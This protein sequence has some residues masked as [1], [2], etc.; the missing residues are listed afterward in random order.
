MTEGVGD[1]PLRAFS[2]SCGMGGRGLRV[3]GVCLCTFAGDDDVPSL[4]SG[5]RRTDDIND[6]IVQGLGDF[7]Y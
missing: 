4:D 2:D 7:A 1:T 5:F 3:L 6:A